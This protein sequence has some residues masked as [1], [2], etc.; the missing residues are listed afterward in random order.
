MPGPEHEDGTPMTAAE[1][2]ALHDEAREA[3]REDDR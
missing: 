3:A 2:K 1:I